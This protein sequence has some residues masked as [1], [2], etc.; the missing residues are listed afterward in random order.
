MLQMLQK[1]RL[2][3]AAKLQVQQK[4]NK[5]TNME[6]VCSE[7]TVDRRSTNSIVGSRPRL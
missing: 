5:G 6:F 1:L 3:L 4:S 7:E 2:Q